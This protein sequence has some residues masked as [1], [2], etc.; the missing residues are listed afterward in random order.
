MLFE[1]GESVENRGR[2]KNDWIGMTERGHIRLIDR[3]D[4]ALFSPP[5]DF[6]D[7]CTL[8]P[9]PRDCPAIA[10]GS[11]KIAADVALR[12]SGFR[13]ALDSSG[14]VWFTEDGS[15]AVG[16]VS[17]SNVVHEL[18]FPVPKSEPTNLAP[19]INGDMWVTALYQRS[20]WHVAA[21]GTFSEFS[22]AQIEQFADVVAGPNARVWFPSRSPSALLS[23]GLDGV[24][25]K[26]SLDSSYPSTFAGIAFDA[27]GNPWYIQSNTQKPRIIRV[28]DGKL[29]EYTPPHD[30]GTLNTLLYSAGNMYFGEEGY[31]ARVSTSTGVI[32]EFPLADGGHAPEVIVGDNTGDIWFSEAPGDRIGRLT[33]GGTIIECSL[34]VEQ[35]GGFT[36]DKYGRAWISTKHGVARLTACHG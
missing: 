4:P 29:D 6:K 28:R 9:R 1:R 20:L 11:V 22:N 18:T 30:L 34:P 36:I 27:D 5:A 12:A 21:D 8:A 26:V 24:L 10:I 23:I 14:N 15:N 3:F 2:W 7:D 17:P 19:G 35:Q 25:S 33:P 16:Y 13:L 31:L 32:K